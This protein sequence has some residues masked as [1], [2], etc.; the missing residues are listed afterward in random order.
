QSQEQSTLFGFL[1]ANFHAHQKIFFAKCF[2]RFNPISRDRTRRSDQLSNVLSIADGSRQLLDE[3]PYG[4]C[5]SKR[6]ILKIM[7]F[8]AVF[9]FEVGILLFIW[10]LGFGIWDLRSQSRR[11]LSAPHRRDRPPRSAR[12]RFPLTTSFLARHSFL[13]IE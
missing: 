11:P 12:R 1:P 9:H 13:P 8:P 6:S 7:S 10:R 2:V 4:F 3:A 5:K